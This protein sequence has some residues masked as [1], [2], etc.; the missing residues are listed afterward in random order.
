[1]AQVFQAFQ[2]LEVKEPLFMIDRT[3]AFGGECK[4]DF[5]KIL[6]AAKVQ[7]QLQIH[8]MEKLILS[9]KLVEKPLNSLN[10]WEYFRS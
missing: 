1:M 3:R 7:D 6:T 4:A 10:Y 5:Q 9:K 2:D 8:A